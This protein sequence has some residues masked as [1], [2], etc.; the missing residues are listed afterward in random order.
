MLFGRPPLWVSTPGSNRLNTVYKSF[1]LPFLAFCFHPLVIGAPWQAHL[2]GLRW[3]LVN[4]S[5]LIFFFILFNSF[6]ALKSSRPLTL[7]RLCRALSCGLSNC[8]LEAFYLFIFFYLTSN[9]VVNSLTPLTFLISHRSLSGR[10]SMGGSE[11]CRQNK[12]SVSLNWMLAA[13]VPF[14]SE[15]AV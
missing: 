1:K 11:N 3:A 7:K 4:L 14:K 12:W 13:Q 6:L 2:R 9:V 10:W 5:H 8:G 15:E